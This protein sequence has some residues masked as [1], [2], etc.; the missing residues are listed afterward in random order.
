MRASYFWLEQVK[1]KRLIINA[2]GASRGNPGPA[3]IGATINDEQGRLVASISQRIGY[4]T[5]NQAEYSAV[6]AAMEKAIRLGAE[7]IDLNL[8]SQLLVRQLS[9]EYRVKSAALKPLYQQVKQLLSLLEGFTITHIPRG[10]NIEAHRLAG[11]ALTSF[12]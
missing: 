9:S 5:N 2:D 7:E 11:R 3:A 4:A 6:I 8:D 10:Q 12:V 1:T